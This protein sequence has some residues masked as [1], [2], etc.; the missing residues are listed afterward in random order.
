VKKSSLIN[1]TCASVPVATFLGRNGGDSKLPRKLPVLQFDDSSELDCVLPDHLS[2]TSDKTEIRSQK[3]PIKKLSQE[4]T[5]GDPLALDI[6]GSG[7]EVELSASSVSVELDNAETII[8]YAS[9]M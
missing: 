6:R 5:G 3:M 9:D 8:E 7:A 4:A 1:I 2:E